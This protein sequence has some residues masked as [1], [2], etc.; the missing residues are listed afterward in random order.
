[1]R[2]L[3]VILLFISTFKSF[4]GATSWF[5]FELEGGHIKVPIKVAGIDGYAI[6]DTGSQVNSINKSFIA[7]N[8][9]SLLKSKKIKVQGVFGVQNTQTYKDVPI[10]FFGMKTKMSGLTEAVLGYH[11][12]SILLG[13][14][15][16]NKFIVQLDY[17]NEKMRLITRDSID[18][19]KFKNI[20]IKSQKGTGMPIVKVGLGDDRY[21]WL[22]LDTGNS[23]GMVVERKVASRNGWLKEAEVESNISMGANTFAI[24]ESFRI[25]QLSFG[26]YNLENVLVTIPA[27]GQKT[28][29]ESQ[30][31]YTGSRIRGRKVEGLIGYDVLKHFLITIDYKEG[32]AHIGLPEEK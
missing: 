27:E 21:M 31:Q 20:D 13:A 26:P 3:F 17:P 23:G 14:S 16:F 1:M 19:T 28:Y 7:K 11:T 10:E 9:L 24:T 25:P 18:L 22:F 30:Y 6:L 4:A 29:L 12:N 15:F 2:F 8:E 5:A 32:L